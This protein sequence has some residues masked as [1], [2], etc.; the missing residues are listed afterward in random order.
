MLLCIMDICRT[1]NVEKRE[2]AN[3]C[4]Q[5]SEI[6]G[7]HRQKEVEKVTADVSEAARSVLRKL[8]TEVVPIEY[9]T[10]TVGACDMF[11]SKKM[12]EYY[13]T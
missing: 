6:S 13:K 8:Y 3:L 2:C 1:N 12:K 7:I 10:V 11:R 9:I 5:F 4:H